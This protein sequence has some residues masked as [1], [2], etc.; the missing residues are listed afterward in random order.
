[1]RRT[2]GD[3]PRPLDSL[4]WVVAA[5]GG[6]DGPAMFRCNNGD[7]T[8][9]FVGPS[10]PLADYTS[11]FRFYLQSGSILGPSAGTPTAP[12]FSAG[13]G[14]L[15]MDFMDVNS[16]VHGTISVVAGG[17]VGGGGHLKS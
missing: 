8:R 14:L 6:G 17:G 9:W 3:A 2:G 15:D 7:Q 13:D 1:M 11:H 10:G 5:G 12:G 4:G 16:F